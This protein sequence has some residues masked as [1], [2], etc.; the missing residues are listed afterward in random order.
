MAHATLKKFEYPETLI[1]EYENWVI[2]L[3]P[4]QTTLGALVMICKDDAYEF[5]KIS[6]T[7]FDEMTKVICDVEKTLKSLFSYDKINYMMLMMTDPHVHFHVIPRYSRDKEFD[8]TNFIDQGW[9]AQPDLGYI[10][11]IN[12]VIF[13]KL[14]ILIQQSWSCKH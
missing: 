10:N 1:H 14:Q 11:A 8:G 13:K 5:S 9:P 2:V 4:K 7:A 6:S 12:D 3:R